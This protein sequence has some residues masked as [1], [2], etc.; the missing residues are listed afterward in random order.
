[1][2]ECWVD[3]DELTEFSVVVVYV[4]PPGLVADLEHGF[5]YLSSSDL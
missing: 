5:V 3:D 2:E 4:W 1:M